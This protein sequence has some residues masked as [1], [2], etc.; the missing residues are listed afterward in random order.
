M[1]KDFQKGFEHTRTKAGGMELQGDMMTGTELSHLKRELGTAAVV[2]KRLKRIQTEAV[3]R[4]FNARG[5]DILNLLPPPMAY[6]SA[7]A[8]RIGVRFGEKKKSYCDIE[9]PTAF[10]L[11]MLHRDIGK[12]FMNDGKP[13]RSMICL[14][15]N[16][17]VKAA[18]L[19]ARIEGCREQF[20]YLEKKY[21]DPLVAAAIADPTAAKHTR[22]T[23]KVE[24]ETLMGLEKT[25]VLGKAFDNLGN[26]LNNI[27]AKASGSEEKAKSDGLMDPNSKS[28]AWTIGQ[29]LILNPGKW[30]SVLAAAKKGSV[31]DAGAKAAPD[32]ANL[33]KPLQAM[34]V[35]K[36]KAMGS[37]AIK[38]LTGGQAA[39]TVSSI[40]SINTISYRAFRLG[41]TFSKDITLKNDPWT[42]DLKASYS[43]NW[44]VTFGLVVPGFGQ[45]DVAMKLSLEYDFSGVIS[46]LLNIIKK[47]MSAKSHKVELNLESVDWEAPAE[48]HGWSRSSQ[49][50]LTDLS[51]L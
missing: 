18:G 6:S 10:S 41:L 46:A 37:S 36:A 24:L 31:G 3:K 44:A 7:V 11:E 22:M 48:P 30:F 8:L 28:L 35:A 38:G 47:K 27:G 20:D 23:W 39:G 21:A 45:A 16:L 50:R 40:V 2:T 34:I 26:T 19:T 1:K 29:E 49:E 33:V 4:A 42:F 14:A 43:R 9:P 17:G 5:G 25:D 13:M 12:L 32:V 51:E 15:G